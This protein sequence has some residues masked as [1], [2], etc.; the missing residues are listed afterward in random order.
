MSLFVLPLLM[1]MPLTLLCRFILFLPYFFS[2]LNVC[3]LFIAEDVD[4]NLFLRLLLCCANIKRSFDR[5][6]RVLCFFRLSA[7]CLPSYNHAVVNR[8]RVELFFLFVEV[9]Y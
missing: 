7:V 5:D 6:L 8:C 4:G 1:A 3:L 9:R 2:F